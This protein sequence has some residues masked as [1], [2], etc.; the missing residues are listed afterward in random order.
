M[1]IG[2]F[3]EYCLGETGALGE[4]GYI[5]VQ[6]IMLIFHFLLFVPLMA[7]NGCGH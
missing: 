7:E 4:N 3:A 6:V 2:E 5:K 1:I